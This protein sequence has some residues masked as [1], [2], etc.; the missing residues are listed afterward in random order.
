MKI[1]GK[2]C[3]TG[4]LITLTLAK[5][6][7]VGSQSG[8]GEATLGG[9]DVWLSAGFCDLQFNGYGG[10]DFN[11]DSWGE[12]TEVSY[13][14]RPIFELAARAGTPLLCPTITTNSF[15]AM[16]A[17]FSA[18]YGYDVRAEVFGS[19]GMVTAGTARTSDMTLYDARGIHIDTARRDTDLLHSAYLGE[20]TAF[21]D[22]VR[23]GTPSVVPGEAAR[24][25][26]SVA[27][28][29]IGSVETGTTVE[30]AR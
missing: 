6:K 28:A 22:A 18:L 9:P 16:H 24:T 7:I 29:A 5:G 26:L 27:L 17:S 10:Y 20:L 8:N 30:V 21:V 13:E 3:E 1:C 25:A 23:A 19:A 15:E 2:L 4:E 14:L 11:R 12:T